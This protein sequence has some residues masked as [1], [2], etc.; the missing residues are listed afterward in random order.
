M[1][2]DRHF[3]LQVNLGMLTRDAVVVQIASFVLLFV[4]THHD[5]HQIDQNYNQTPGLGVSKKPPLPDGSALLR[6]C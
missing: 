3:I 6:L 4:V 5:L 1:Y 2:R